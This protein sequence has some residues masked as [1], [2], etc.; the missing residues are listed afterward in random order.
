VVSSSTSFSSQNFTDGSTST[1]S[2]TVSSNSYVQASTPIITISG[3][4]IPYTPGASA[5]LT[6]LSIS[7]GIINNATLKLVLNSTFTFVTGVVNTTSTFVGASAN[8]NM[9]SSSQAALGVSGATMTGGTNSA[10]TINTPTITIASNGFTTGLE[11]LYTAAGTAISGLTSGTSYYVSIISPNTLGQGPNFKL[12]T[13]STGAVAGVGVVLASSQTKTSADTFTLAPLAFA[14]TGLAGGIQLQWSDDNST[15][16]NATTGNYA[17]SISSQTFSASGATSLWDLGT[18]SH[19]YLRLKET[20][21]TAGGVTYTATDNE[22]YTI[23][24]H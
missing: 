19:R 7:S 14:N 11:V 16:F 23:S 21:P 20:A 22:R 6:A 2:I 13:T 4:K 18:I 9:T 15:F 12:A 3:I 17:A 8:F 10:Y 5:G 1:G 24:G